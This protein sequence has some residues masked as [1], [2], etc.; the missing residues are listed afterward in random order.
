MRKF[1]PATVV[2]LLVFVLLIELLFRSNVEMPRA[3]VLIGTPILLTLV[4]LL[5]KKR[6]RPQPRL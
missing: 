6:R 4:F 2:G 3:A 5:A 1:L